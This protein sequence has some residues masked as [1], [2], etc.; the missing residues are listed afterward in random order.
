MP[1]NTAA[2]KHRPAPGRCHRD[3][4]DAQDDLKHEV[5]GLNALLYV[6]PKAN[7]A[8]MR[9]E[10]YPAFFGASWRPSPARHR[11]REHPKARQAARRT[12]GEN[13]VR[14]RATSPLRTATAPAWQPEPSPIYRSVDATLGA[15]ARAA[16]RRTKDAKWTTAYTG[17]DVV[18][19]AAI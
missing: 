16:S 2:V 19:S 18:F 7:T 14:H 1:G 10:R 15:F 9:W 4:I 17:Q 8:T 13:L 6:T 3:N 12:R 11:R 5:H